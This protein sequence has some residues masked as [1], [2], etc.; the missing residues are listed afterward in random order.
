[1]K[2]ED[3]SVRHQRLWGQARIAVIGIA[4]SS[5]FPALAATPSRIADV[6]LYPDS[7]TVVRVATVAPGARTVELSCLPATFDPQSL[8]VEPGS[9]IRVGDVRTETIS[10]EGAIGCAMNSLDTQIRALE[11]QRLTLDTQIRA[12]E[13]SVSYLKAVSE[14]PGADGR[15]VAV[16]STALAKSVDAL[17]RTAQDIFSRQEQLKRR[18]AELKSRLDALQTN[19][20]KAQFDTVRTLH[21]A[22]AA[23]QG[24]DIRV[25]YQ[26]SAAGWRPVYQANLDPA[27]SNVVIERQATV[28][29]ATGEDWRGVRLRLSTGQPRSGVR[30]PEPHTWHVNVVPLQ[31]AGRAHEMAPAPAPAPAA[32]A[33]GRYGLSSGSNLFEVAT[34]QTD[35]AT[36]F[37][38]PGTV[39]LPTDAQKVTF[40]LATQALPATLLARSTPR[41]DRS[42]Y[43]IAMVDRPEGV[44]PAGNMQLRRDGATVGTSSWNPASGD[45][46]IALSFGKDDLVSVSAESPRTFQRSVGLLDNRSERQY[47][48]T[49]TVRSRHRNP[50]DIEILEA[51]PVSQAEDIKVTARFSPEPASRDWEHREGVIAW[52]QTLKPGESARFS[53]DYLITFPKDARV[54][55]LR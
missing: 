45:Q 44:W 29:Q 32:A 43:L 20:N 5:V 55:G 30:G 12:N 21:I 33:A 8:R 15:T 4:W 28:A 22:V 36:E 9:G 27:R 53:A 18:D 41:L 14:R 2:Q 38:L 54:S 11:D 19:R 10:R 49:Y 3:L 35:F 37:E 23:P 51:M 52:Q 50:I 17:T 47:G 26:T 48:S 31:P 6:T 25:S 39:E 1:M 16:D 46:R 7:A 40:S 24:G 34:V 42:A 13:L